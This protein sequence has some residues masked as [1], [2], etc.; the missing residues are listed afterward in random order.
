MY[1]NQEDDGLYLQLDRSEKCFRDTLY[2]R[3]LEVEPGVDLWLKASLDADS[4]HFTFAYSVDGESY[5]ELDLTVSAEFLYP[6]NFA[7]YKCYTAPRIGIF[8]MGVLY[9]PSGNATFKQ[10]EYRA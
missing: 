2:Q 9:Q 1:E 6:E 4:Q 3:K 5:K 7:R 8:A 10:F